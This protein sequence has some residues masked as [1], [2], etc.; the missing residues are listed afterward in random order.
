MKKYKLIKEYP[1]ST[2]LGTIKTTQNVSI[3]GEYPEF[4]EEVIEK[5][6]EILSMCDYKFNIYSVKRLSDGEV[7]TIGDRIKNTNYPHISDKIYEI[8][9]VDNKIRVYYQGYDFLKNISHCKKVLFTTK[10]GVDI[11][12]GDSY[13]NVYDFKICNKLTAKNPLSK[14][15]KL[16]FST[17]EAAEEYIL[18][19]KPCLS[20]KDVNDILIEFWKKG[21]INTGQ[22]VDLKELIKSKLWKE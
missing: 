20:L 3:E 4:W 1:G 21:K 9:L 22:Y 18:M 14:H 7:F 17:K 10:D 6:Y 11:F 16:V 19:N 12:E 13:Y 2:E 15:K 5:D 8:S